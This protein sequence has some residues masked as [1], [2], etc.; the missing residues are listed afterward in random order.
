MARLGLQELF[1]PE[2][3]NNLGVVAGQQPISKEGDILARQA[4]MMS[5]GLLTKAKNHF[6][7]S[8]F[9]GFVGNTPD[10]EIARVSDDWFYK[11][12]KSLTKDVPLLNMATTLLDGAYTNFISPYG[13]SAAGLIEL[14]PSLFYF[15]VLKYPARWATKLFSGIGKTAISGVEKIAGRELQVPVPTLLRK[16]GPTYAERTIEMGIIGASVKRREEAS[17]T[18][19]MAPISQYPKDILKEF[20]T[21]GP[22]L[23]GLFV[24]GLDSLLASRGIA[25]SLSREYNKTIPWSEPFKSYWRT[26]DYINR[27]LNKFSDVFVNAMPDNFSPESIRTL[28]FQAETAQKINNSALY[29]DTILKSVPNYLRDDVKTLLESIKNSYKDVKSDGLIAKRIID[30][31]RGFVENLLEKASLSSELKDSILKS[32]DSI[33]SRLAELNFNSNALVKEVLN[34]KDVFKKVFGGVLDLDAIDNTI[35]QTIEKNLQPLRQELLKARQLKDKT[36]I[37]QIQSRIEAEKNNLDFLPENVKD[38]IV[39]AVFENKDLLGELVK[40]EPFTNLTVKRLDSINQ[41]MKELKDVTSL[42][43]KNIDHIQANDI[44]NQYINAQKVKEAVIPDEIKQTS[45]D[46]HTSTAEKNKIEGNLGKIDGIEDVVKNNV[47][48]KEEVMQHLGPKA[49]EKVE[50]SVPLRTLISD[51]D[52]TTFMQNIAHLTDEGQVKKISALNN[53]LDPYGLKRI[54]DFIQST[55][56]KERIDLFKKYEQSI[57]N[58]I[59]DK[60]TK[61][62][63][64]ELL[65]NSISAFGYDEFDGPLYTSLVFH[66]ILPEIS[67][68]IYLKQLKEALINNNEKLLNSLQKKAFD[69]SKK[70]FGLTNEKYKNV[71][72]DFIEALNNSVG[73]LRTKTSLKTGIVGS[74]PEEI[75]KSAKDKLVRETLQTNDELQKVNEV[76]LKADELNAL[77]KSE[78]GIDK[79]EFAKMV[80]EEEK[81]AKEIIISSISK[82]NPQ[83]GLIKR[84]KEENVNFNNVFNESF[85]KDL[86]ESVREGISKVKSGVKAIPKELEPLA[87]EARKYKSAEEFVNAAKKR[88]VYNNLKQRAIDLGPKAELV[89]GELGRIGKKSIMSDEQAAKIAKSQIEP[90]RTRA[91]QLG[92]VDAALIDFYNQATKGIKEV[93][94]EKSPQEI[95]RAKLRNKL[96]GLLQGQAK[97]Q[98]RGVSLEQ[99]I[100]STKRGSEAENLKL[101]DTLKDETTPETEL[102]KK[103]DISKEKK[104]LNKVEKNFSDAEKNILQYL[105]EGKSVDEI[106]VLTKLSIKDVDSIIN[107]IMEKSKKLNIDLAIFNPKRSVDRNKIINQIK[108]GF[109]QTENKIREYFTEKGMTFDEVL[110]RL[111]QEGITNENGEEITRQDLNKMI[112]NI[113]K[114][115]ESYIN[116]WKLKGVKLIKDFI[117]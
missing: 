58:Q 13:L 25:K 114:R 32:V 79:D 9:L 12:L 22:Y 110:E 23:G 57:L 76:I 90:L 83:S 115:L 31:G 74:T 50:K 18:G 1:S 99:P 86:A 34:N 70:Y 52:F 41:L 11:D 61:G 111:R 107:S 101:V 55:G 2:N 113:D 20:L 81:N 8:L 94:L 98:P 80:Q 60:L 59:K 45:K 88:I 63:Y 91:H 5:S 117:K 97:K 62:E 24:M 82:E 54:N 100:K 27:E 87:E 105:A 49:R 33:T 14:F 96:S 56:I 10:P 36:L 21:P 102:I 40:S 109:T 72:G 67:S 65:K 46:F 16:L 37:S 95:L 104:L 4:E 78:L 77:L 28:R 17:I 108:E 68:K 116:S 3:L 71:F 29:A 64:A 112:K 19:E 73:E 39:S 103:Q 35:K 48:A 93:K 26:G 66:L 92:S 75:S 84:I 42:I 51:E 6:L 89:F 53:V 106:V 15:G 7:S 43:S 30:G 69:L 47:G 85:I 38:V 44:F